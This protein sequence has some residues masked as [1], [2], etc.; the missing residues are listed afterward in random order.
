MRE[1][2]RPGAPGRRPKPTQ[3]GDALADGFTTLGRRPLC[4]GPGD[5]YPNAQADR[6]DARHEMWHDM[7]IGESRDSRIISRNHEP[8]Y[9]IVPPLDDD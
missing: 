2:S 9:T 4:K 5:I 7:G 3:E 1:P 8:D 6:I